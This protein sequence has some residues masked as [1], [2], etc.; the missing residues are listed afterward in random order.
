M[1]EDITKFF[2]LFPLGHEKG[3]KTEILMEHEAVG[4]LSNSA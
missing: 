3:R 1:L 4:L 2:F